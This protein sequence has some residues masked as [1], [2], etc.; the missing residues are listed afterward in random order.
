MN[1]EKCNGTGSA[2]VVH[3]NYGYNDDKCR[4]DGAWIAG[5]CHYCHGTGQV[6]DDTP[7]WIAAGKKMKADRLQR[8]ETLYSEAKRL[9]VT[10]A[11]LS[12]METGRADPNCAHQQPSQSKGGAA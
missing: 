12:A 7:A 4:C 5:R 6:S 2:G 11:Q 9:R 1:C 3:N 10:P 8:G